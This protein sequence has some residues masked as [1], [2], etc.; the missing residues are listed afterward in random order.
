MNTKLYFRIHHSGLYEFYHLCN[1]AGP[2]MIDS[3][4]HRE[5]TR[6]PNKCPK[7]LFQIPS[8][9]LFGGNNFETRIY[10]STSTTRRGIFT[11]VPLTSK[12][13]KELVPIPDLL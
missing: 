11:H 12:V 6:Y 5:H 3:L 8:I 7:C 1:I 9:Y 2:V 4:Y 10:S 13:C